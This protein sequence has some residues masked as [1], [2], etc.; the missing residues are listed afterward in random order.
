[1]DAWLQAKLPN[2]FGNTLGKLERRS[3]MIL[4]AEPTI[5]GRV[6][7]YAAALKAIF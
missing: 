3:E 2:K 7:G 4:A 1:M 5:P 6:L